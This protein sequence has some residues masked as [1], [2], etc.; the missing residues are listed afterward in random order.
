MAESPASKKVIAIDFDDVIMN[1][2]A[3]FMA[4]SNRV[5]GSHLTYEQLTNYDEWWILYGCDP[6]TM[7]TR[8]RQFYQ[9]PEHTVVK[10]VPGVLEAI[11]RLSPNYSLQVVTSRP[12]SVRPI[13]EKWLEK[14]LPGYFEQLHFTNIF[15]SE[16]NKKP[17][18]KSEVCR[19]IGALALIDDAIKHVTDAAENSIIALMPDRPWNRKTT[20]AGV[21]RLHSWNEIADWIEKNI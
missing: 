19:E 1:F 13:V 11:A 10:P 9:S 16:D 14:F 12:D 21:T 4:F 20:P 2:H 5:Y 18:K 3:E 7:V 17:R 15:A 8:A 6:A